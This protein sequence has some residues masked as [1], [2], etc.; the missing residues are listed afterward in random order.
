MLSRKN[1]RTYGSLSAT[2]R[3]QESGRPSR[4]VRPSTHG[5]DQRSHRDS[6]GDTRCNR[7]DNDGGAKLSV[8][9]WLRLDGTS[10]HVRSVEI[11]RNVHATSGR[12][13]FQRTA[14]PRSTLA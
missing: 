8:V 9:L 11:G 10:S 7:R 14:R 6:G 2:D 12:V 1:P 13:L 5:G 3:L 4:H